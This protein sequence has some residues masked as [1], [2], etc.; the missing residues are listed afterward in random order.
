MRRIVILCCL[1]FFCSH[2]FA[3]GFFLEVKVRDGL[4]MSMIK[5]SIMKILV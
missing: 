4:L 2:A 1:I 5:L 3:D